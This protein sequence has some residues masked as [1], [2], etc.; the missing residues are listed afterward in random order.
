MK[1]QRHIWTYAAQRSLQDLTRSRRHYNTTNR[2]QLRRTASG[3]ACCWWTSRWPLALL[4]ACRIM[5]LL[6]SQRNAFRYRSSR[7]GILMFCYKPRRSRGYRNPTQ[8][9]LGVVG[10]YQSQRHQH[11]FEIW[12]PIIIP[13][14]TTACHAITTLC[15]SGFFVHLPR[16]DLSRLCTM[17]VASA[18]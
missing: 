18:C 10:Q 15:P 12:I 17:L 9:R 14:D 5:R 6:S 16:K 1:C 8:N 7:M 3:E 4:E 13:A 2:Y 11:A